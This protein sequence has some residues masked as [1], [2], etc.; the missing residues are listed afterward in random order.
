VF[1]HGAT[2]D[3]HSWDA[4]VAALRRRYRIV[5]LDLRGH[6]ES[7]MEGSFSF[8]DAVGDVLALLHRLRADRLVLIG[9]SL[10]GN[11]AQEIVY[12]A[13]E[14]VDG[15]VVADST[16]N[17]APRHPLQAAM[18]IAAL[19]PLGLISREAFLRKAASATAEDEEV[20]QYVLEVNEN[21]ST[22]AAVRILV[23][24][25]ACAL[26]PDSDYQL[27][28]PT[29]LLHGDRDKMGDIAAGTRAWAERESLAEY[30]TIPDAG[31][32]S[33]QDNPQAFTTELGAFLDR[34]L[35]SSAA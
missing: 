20:Q 12:R 19:A 1:L 13:P 26:R 10:G 24:L 7:T 34:A 31:H 15:L 9:L 2:L 33:N 30:V 3:H 18:T 11:I 21:R 17:T 32:A 29:L 27:P 8:E 23:S 14:L 5:T 6:G 22:R 28:I 16:C 35:I 25:L 4:Q